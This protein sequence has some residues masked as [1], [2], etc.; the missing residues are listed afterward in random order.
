MGVWRAA[1]LN[2]KQPLIMQTSIGVVLEDEVVE[3]GEALRMQLHDPDGAVLDV[4][5]PT[6]PVD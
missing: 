3:P 4:S 6:A 1:T 2:N 5:A